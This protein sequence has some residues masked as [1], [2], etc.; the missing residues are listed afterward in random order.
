MK[1]RNRF[2]FYTK[3]MSISTHTHSSI[4]SNLY[5]KWSIFVGDPTQKSDHLGKDT[6]NLVI[7]PTD[8]SYNTLHHHWHTSVD[9]HSRRNSE[10]LSLCWKNTVS[11]NQR[12]MFAL[13]IRYGWS[14]SYHSI[15]GP[16]HLREHGIKYN[17]IL[18]SITLRN[19]PH[20]PECL[21]RVKPTVE[22]ELGC[23]L[24]TE[25]TQF[26]H[27]PLLKFYFYFFWG[28]AHGT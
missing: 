11:M 1:H 12:L 14:A 24:D 5:F 7:L 9:G 6:S 27:V 23:Y 21:L 28:G 13:N 20:T 18:T 15:A 3:Y 2:L 26:F 4:G 10:N 22:K 25:H 8:E 16:L 19:W 17:I